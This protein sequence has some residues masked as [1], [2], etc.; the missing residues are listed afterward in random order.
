MMKPEE[1]A[2]RYAPPPAWNEGFP[3]LFN[4]HPI[5]MVPTGLT[6]P[7]SAE[8]RS[9]QAF[10]DEPLDRGIE[11]SRGTF[12][13][14][15]LK[16]LQDVLV[17]DRLHIYFDA[18]I[19]FLK[20]G[21]WPSPDNMWHVDG[22]I[23]LQPEST[24][25]IFPTYDMWARDRLLSYPRFH[26]FITGGHSQT[27]Y[28]SEP[29]VAVV[30]RLMKPWT[31]I[32]DSLGLNARIVNTLFHEHGS[33]VSYDG[34][35]LHRAVSASAPGWRLHVRMIETNTIRTTRVRT[36]SEINMVYV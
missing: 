30:P 14:S 22:G 20:R 9:L 31:T 5:H 18:K 26:S 21:Q 11:R 3:F 8:L 27:Q 16:K 32:G 7:S 4:R 2:A 25:L 17:G 1:L 13:E 34:F 6:E 36:D 10:R 33:I 23:S 35:S 15:V 12:L 19:Q 28:A 24:N 29:I